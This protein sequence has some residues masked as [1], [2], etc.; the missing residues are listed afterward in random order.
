MHIC[1]DDVRYIVLDVCRCRGKGTELVERSERRKTECIGKATCL[2]RSAK[3][4]EC[5]HVMVM[6]SIWLGSK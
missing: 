1:E 4:S 6:L 3:L 2:I 5:T